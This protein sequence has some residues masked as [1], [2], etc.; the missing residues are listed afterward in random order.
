MPIHYFN[1][2]NSAAACP[3]VIEAI[4]RANRGAAPAYG[5]DDWS[6]RLEAVLSTWFGAPVRAYT[7]LSGTAANSL[8]LAAFSPPW[9]TVLTHA[10]AHIERD[11]CGA[12]EFFTG[13]AKLSLVSGPEAKIA[14]AAL[15]AR[16]AYFG[17]EVHW[18]QPR[19]VSI[20][21]ATERGATYT[22]A[23]ISAIAAI[24]REHRLALHVDG[25]RFANAVVALGCEPADLTWRAGV[26][27]LSL[28]A[29]KNGGMNAEAVVFF[30]RAFEAQERLA[31]FEFRRKRAGH[32]ACKGRFFA[33]QLLGLF[34][35]DAWRRNAERA[36]RLAARIGVAA[37]R[38]LTVPVATNQVF[39]ALGE[40]RIERLAQRGFK[41]YAWGPAGSG[42]ARFVVS[43]D[44]PESAV[45]ALCA[46]LEALN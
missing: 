14:P 5:T 8:A 44:T 26:D 38:F 46:A 19:V 29:I 37:Q 27:V 31:D 43:W 41:F 10:E 36:N 22:P 33:A 3:E 2:D 28:G 15:R 9:G 16:L 18:V 45:D 13:G 12:P 7:V 24:A 32:L 17:P 6:R 1:S 42:E 39:V 20:T 11:E 40:A 30:E 23:E 34:E 25:A 4:V 21:Q 35:G